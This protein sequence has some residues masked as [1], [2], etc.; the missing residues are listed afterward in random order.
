MFYMP[1]EV[2]N[3]LVFCFF[4]TCVSVLP[5]NRRVLLDVFL[6]SNKSFIHH[7]F[8]QGPLAIDQLRHLCDIQ[9]RKVIMKNDGCKICS[10]KAQYTSFFFDTAPT[11][12]TIKITHEKK[13]YGLILHITYIHHWYA[14]SMITRP[15][16][17]H[18]RFTLGR[19]SYLLT[20][21]PRHH[22]L[23]D[24]LGIDLYYAR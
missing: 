10:R 23:L 19:I 5:W 22:E 20:G 12:K 14:R 21:E 15:Q 17:L 13:L 11:D 3:L 1:I 18:F 4:G 2:N 9:Y 8:T 16:Y 7:S 24:R 6:S